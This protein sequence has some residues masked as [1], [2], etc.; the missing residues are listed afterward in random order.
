MCD[1]QSTPILVIAFRRPNSL[2]NLLEKIDCLSIRDVVIS[3]DN[4]NDTDSFD[5]KQRN[6]TLQIAKYWKTK[7]AHNVKII[8]REFNYGLYNHFYESLSDFFSEFEFGVILED[9]ISF[10]DMFINFVDENIGNLVSTR[11]WSIQGFNP[12]CPQIEENESEQVVSLLTT[13]FHTVSGWASSRQNIDLFLHLVK[14]KIDI[15]SLLTTISS[16]FSLD[17]FLKNAFKSVWYKKYNR[18]M[19]RLYPGGWD[20]IWQVSGWYSGKPSITFSRSLSWENDS[21]TINSSHSGARKWIITAR[22]TEDEINLEYNLNQ[23]NSTRR[24]HDVRK[25]EIWGIKRKYAWFYFFRVYRIMKRIRLD[26]TR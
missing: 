2:S 19:K 5:Y 12:F 20:N 23:I 11:Y 17:P 21:G 4:C 14:F 9:D 16:K 1:I 13:N 15:I 8:N 10:N 22:F 3:I 18:A 24:A 6:E 25:L 26:E 7:T